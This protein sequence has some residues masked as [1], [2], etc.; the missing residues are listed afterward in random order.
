MNTELIYELTVLEAHIHKTNPP[1]L[2][3]KAT[4]NASSGGHTNPRL[5]RRVYVKFPEDG[6]QEYDFLID[7]PEGPSSD[8][9]KS[10]TVEDQWEDFPKELKG[11]RVYGKTN[12][13]EKILSQ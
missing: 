11:V 4:G 5:E 6:I 2:H 12:S 7:V 13:M 1:R 10:H 3:V 8:D 9:I